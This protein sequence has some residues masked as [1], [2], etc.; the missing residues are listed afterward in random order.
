M[1]RADFRAAAGQAALSPVAC[2]RAR[3]RRL[4][5]VTYRASTGTQIDRR[6]A[7]YAAGEIANMSYNA[8]IA[9][10][11]KGA[12]SRRG[13][14]PSLRPRRRPA[15]SA[16][17]HP[18]RSRRRHRPQ[19]QPAR[20]RYQR[21]GRCRHQRALFTPAASTAP[22][23]KGNCR[24]VGGR[25]VPERPIAGLCRDLRRPALSFRRRPAALWRQSDRYRPLWTAGTDQDPQR[26]VNIGQENVPAGK[27]WYWAGINQPGSD[28]VNFI[29]MRRP[30]RPKTRRPWPSRT[31]STP[32][33]RW[34]CWSRPSS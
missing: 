22:A 23:S 30:N 19:Q 18:F 16:Q 11:D 10:D 32:R 28:L 2:A 24:Q 7:L 12:R 20:P 29:S 25:T 13:S 8:Q 4:G 27:T 31:A 1:H 33:L 3:L 17:R 5:G 6:A 21:P 26:I 14:A 9:S 15:R 34:R